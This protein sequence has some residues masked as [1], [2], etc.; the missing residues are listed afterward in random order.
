V[1]LVHHWNQTARRAALCWVS[2]SAVGAAIVALPDADHR[3]LMLSETHGPSALDL[4]GVAVL[5]AGWLPV[6]LALWR[7]RRVVPVGVWAAA[8][9][10][11][12]VGAIALVVTIR[13]DLGW[14]WLAAVTIL[15]AAQVAPLVSLARRGGVVV[16]A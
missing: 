13:L 11:G 2:G 9:V 1:Q 6:P 15:V 10:L 7:N 5:L 16:T 8:A 14:W 4:V 12:V 3:V